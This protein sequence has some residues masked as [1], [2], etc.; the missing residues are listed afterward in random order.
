MDKFKTLL[1]AAKHAATLSDNWQF[2]FT[3]DEKYDAESLIGISEV[4][5]EENPLEEDGF[6]VVSPG[7][8]IGECADGS[9][10]EW[11][12]LPEDVDH[13]SLPSSY[14]PKGEPKLCPKCKTPIQ[15]GSRFCGKCGERLG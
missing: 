6:Y 11:L 8:A 10:I 7:G 13:G 2:A 15:I 9:E 1:E 4:S 5:D 3:K 14:T 12:F